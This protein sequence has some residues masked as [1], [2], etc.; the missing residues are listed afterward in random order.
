M[1][2]PRCNKK[3]EEAIFQNT[4]VDYCPQCLGIF[5]DEDELRQ[6]K[7][8]R[9]R[10]LRWVD[11]DLWKDKNKFKIAYGIRLCPCCRLPLYEVYYSDTRVATKSKRAS[12]SFSPSSLKRDSVAEDGRSSSIS[13]VVVDVCNVCHGIWL[14]RGEFK[15]IV[16]YLKKEAEY[17]ILNDYLKTLAEE[18]WEIFTGPETFREEILDFMAIFKII[19]YKFLARYPQLS[20]IISNLPR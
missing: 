3:L 4:G 2:C 20:N 14:D 16:G 1:E 6:A 7:D 15:K 11:I 8:E 10:G 12:L 17:E 9:D 5:F 13:G 18:F 19:N